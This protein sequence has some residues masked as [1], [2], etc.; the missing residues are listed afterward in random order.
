MDPAVMTGGLATPHW[1]P[2]RTTPD[3]SILSQWDSS[4]SPPP[5]S[6][7]AILEQKSHKV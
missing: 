1:D 3:P 2:R 6:A 4:V 5:P 7:T